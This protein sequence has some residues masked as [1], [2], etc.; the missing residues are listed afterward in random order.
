MRSV[1]V[2]GIG[3][4]TPLGIGREKTWQALLSGACGYAP[5][6]PARCAL[7]FSGNRASALA[8]SAAKEAVEDSGLSPKD[9]QNADC[10]LGSGKPHLNCGPPESPN[11]PAIHVY[12]ALQMGGEI[13]CIQA[14]CA[15]G[16]HSL[17]L[18]QRR[19]A[20]GLCDVAL[21]GSSE[22][23]LHPLYIAGFRRMGVVSGSLVKPFDSERCGFVLGESAAIFVLEDLERARARGARIYGEI[24]GLMRTDACHPTA[25]DSHEALAKSIRASVIDNNPPDFIHAHGTATTSGDSF[26]AL[27]LEEAF[28]K[29]LHKI[30]VAATKASTGHLL[31]ASGSVQIGFSFLALRDQTIPATLHTKSIGFDLDLV[32]EKN[33]QKNIESFLSLSYG[34]G[35]PIA[36]VVGRRMG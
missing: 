35:G 4:V 34:F 26:E 20:L 23:S 14:A 28:G 24:L 31:S 16:A 25:F 18:A 33:R 22:S 5:G 29:V 13:S 19:I 30:P 36:C 21:A 17:L 32:V 12:R 6:E 11:L 7:D 15:T 9:L 27:A 3:L 10:V 1:V 2:T 8:L